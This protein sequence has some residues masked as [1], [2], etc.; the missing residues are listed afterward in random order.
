MARSLK[1]QGWSYV[2]RTDI[3]G[4]Y[5]HIRRGPLMRQLKRHVSDPVLLNLVRQYLHYSVERGG[6]FYTP[7]RGIC[8][9]C[10]LSPLLAG[11]CLWAM[12]TYYEAQQPALRYV[13][14]MDD[15]VIFTR[16]R[17][18]LRRAVRTLNA[19]FASGGYR[20][21]PDKTFIGKTDKGFDWMGIQFN[22]S[23]ITGVAPRALTSH[24]ERCRRLYEQ[25]W[26]YGK[27]K[28]RAR[29][30]EYVK[31]WTIW[32]NAMTGYQTRTPGHRTP[33]NHSLSVGARLRLG[34]TMSCLLSCGAAWGDTLPSCA[35]PSWTQGS[36]NAVH[37]TV[38]HPGVTY[39]AG[40]PT[41]YISNSGVT[42]TLRC[43][44]PPGDTRF[45]YGTGSLG[46]QPSYVR[47]IQPGIY[48][49]SNYNYQEYYDHMR[50][51]TSGATLTCVGRE[52]RTAL[53]PGDSTPA[54]PL[55]DEISV[56]CINDQDGAVT[57]SISV[58]PTTL[59]APS[60]G[61]LGTKLGSN[62]GSNNGNYKY[63]S[64]MFGGAVGTGPGGAGPWADDSKTRTLGNNLYNETVNSNSACDVQWADSGSGQTNIDFGV[65][66]APA[67]SVWGSPGTRLGADVRTTTLELSCTDAAALTGRTG[68]GQIRGSQSPGD[69]GDLGS[70]NPG[71]AFRAE[72]D[73]GDR[74]L[75]NTSTSTGVTNTGSNAGVE[76]RQWVLT[77][78]PVSTG[79]R[80]GPGKV[81]ATATVDLFL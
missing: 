57:V 76:Q 5:G 37:I 25:A 40:T 27:K 81:R 28:T 2:C 43:I 6:E 33:G 64:Y 74:I 58:Q 42:R 19:F 48:E 54:A 46:Q 31:R 1:Q 20:Q 8:R 14:Y 53:F 45:Y 7:R 32:R 18:H 72:T 38:P 36:G 63:R 15:I 39:P 22:G 11:F 66:P 59:A 56:P 51:I 41:G 70:D 60:D 67:E 4:F 44:M 24:R 9:G 30:A 13:R 80:P 10:A 71:V 61:F 79:V 16:T 21:H 68:T 29:V 50:F 52:T 77:W 65:L 26:R 69:T 34:A 75:V 62:I 12:D 3:Q 49:Y 47:R 35:G 73:A 17:W 23:G 78:Y 55:G